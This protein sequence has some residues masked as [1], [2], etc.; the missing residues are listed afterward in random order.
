MPAV[1]A[2]NAIR[3]RVL[4][5][6]A[7]PSCGAFGDTLQQSPANPSLGQIPCSGFSQNLGIGSDSRAKSV[8]QIQWVARK[9]PTR[10][11]REFFRR[12]REISGAIGEF[13]PQGGGVCNHYT[14]RR[15]GRSGPL[16]DPALLLSET[17]SR[18]FRRLIEPVSSI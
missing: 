14:P 8:Q 17:S 6:T 2:E 15:C 18:T 16:A 4:P 9:F 10:W 11:S 5:A 7:F 12:S 1:H 3:A 13:W